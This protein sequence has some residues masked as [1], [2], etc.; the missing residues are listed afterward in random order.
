M[1]E[2]DKKSINIRNTFFYQTLFLEKKLFQN[3]L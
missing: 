1:L 2:K 3:F